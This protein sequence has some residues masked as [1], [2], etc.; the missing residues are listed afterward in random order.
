[1]TLRW[2]SARAW[3]SS[4]PDVGRSQMQPSS[5]S[6]IFIYHPPACPSPP[7]FR[8]SP[9][10]RRA[11]LLSAH[12]RLGAC[13]SINLSVFASLPHKRDRLLS[14]EVEGRLPDTASL[15]ASSNRSTTEE[16]R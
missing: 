13:A 14:H 3:T 2:I 9:A 10:A 4:G 7:W 11:E 12:R 5:G 1:M 6:Y 15:A 8:G 16:L